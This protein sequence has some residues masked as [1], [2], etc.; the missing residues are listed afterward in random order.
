MNVIRMD[1]GATINLRLLVEDLW[2]LLKVN[3]IPLLLG[4]RINSIFDK[5]KNTN[6]ISV[7][8]EYPT[9]EGVEKTKAG[10]IKIK[11]R[12][13]DFYDEHSMDENKSLTLVGISPKT[14]KKIRAEMEE[15][16]E[17]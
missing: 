13:S 5:S 10:A 2:L 1:A 7:H 14:L 11:I 6:A 17:K 16:N 15:K 4:Y 9:L 3:M 12:F 8:Y